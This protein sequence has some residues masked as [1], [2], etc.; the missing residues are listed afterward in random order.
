MATTYRNPSYMLMDRAYHIQVEC[1]NEQFPDIFNTAQSLKSFA[2][3]ENK[4]KYNVTDPPS[5]M[6]FIVDIMFGESRDCEWFILKYPT[7]KCMEY[8]I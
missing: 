3:L 1:N 5:T 4:G 6:V 8:R 7:A 2:Q